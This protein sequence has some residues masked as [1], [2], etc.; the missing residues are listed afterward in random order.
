MASSV[1]I[2]IPFCKNICTYCD[3]CKIYYDEKLATSYIDA[4]KKEIIDRYKG[5]EIK[6]IYIGGGTPSSLSINNIKHLFDIIKMFKTND[7]VEFT[8]E[9]NLLDIEE[10]KLKYLKDNKVNRISIGIETINKE[11]QVL[12]DRVVSKTDIKEKIN[13]AKKYFDNINIDLIYA[14]KDE[15]I[16]ILKEDLDFITSFDP[17]HVSCYSLILEEHTILNNLKIEP[18]DEDLDSEMYYY[19]RSYLLDK[20]YKHIEISNYAKDGYKPVHNLVYWNNEEYYGFGAG[21]S[22]YLGS[23]RYSNTRNVFKYIKGNY[24]Y[25]VENLSNYDIIENEMILG[26]RKI[27]GVNKR[28]FYQ[29]Y[30]KRID[31]YFDIDSLVAKGLLKD[32]NDYIFIPSDKLYVSNS[33]LINFIGRINE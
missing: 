29:K 2:H 20:G 28:L 17:A 15:T 27:E 19:I 18:I 13:L 25:L 24:N 1:Y 9:F 16:D 8:F 7:L 33:I 30:N 10:E 11:G 6:T 21:A 26:L 23:V 32:E 22:G 3:F 4:L 31:D 12:L 5:E 14:Y